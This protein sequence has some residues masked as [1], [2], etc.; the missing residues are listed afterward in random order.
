MPE[1]LL[2]NID[3]NDFTKLYRAAEK[4]DQDAK[5]GYLPYVRQRITVHPLRLNGLPP[6]VCAQIQKLTL[7]FRADLRYGS[8]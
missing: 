6:S 7:P 8:S 3:K 1:L 5:S 4:G 2:L